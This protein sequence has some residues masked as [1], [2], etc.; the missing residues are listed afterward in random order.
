MSNP[1]LISNNLLNL[2]SDLRK[3][4]LSNV[5]PDTFRRWVNQLSIGRIK[6]KKELYLMIQRLKDGNEEF[7]D[8]A[9][10]EGSKPV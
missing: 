3:F 6:N 4:I 5:S 8:L 9:K 2:P 7:S 10:F 1:K